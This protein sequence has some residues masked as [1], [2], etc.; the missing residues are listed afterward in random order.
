MF[1]NIIQWLA[2]TA[3]LIGLASPT[4]AQGPAR[5]PL[6]DPA[7]RAQ[8]QKLWDQYRD[9][10]GRPGGAEAL[11]QIMS[12]RAL[13][14]TKENS[15]AV[16]ALLRSNFSPDEKVFLIRIAG[17]QA[18]EL[19][20]KQARAD[21]QAFI[22]ALALGTE[23]PVIGEAAALM[24]SRMGFYP[25]SLTV[26]ARARAKNHISDNDYFGDLAHL[27]PAATSAQDQTKILRLLSDGKNSLARE[28]LANLLLDRQ[29]VTTLT[30][31]AITD[32]IAFLAQ[33]EPA[34]SASPTTISGVDVL[35]YGYWMN[36]LVGLNAKATGEPERIV[37]ARLLKIDGANPKTLI[38]VLNY[39]P[40]AVLVRSALDRRSLDKID[41]VVADFGEKSKNGWVQELVATAR[42]NL[43]EPKK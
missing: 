37:M 32:S 16:L 4:M 30:P 9:K 26:L 22:S 18:V 35:R 38:A 15:A 3:V 41:A 34:F 40:N 31:A 14:A 5:S 21:I 43:V 23:D 11:V 20:D 29:I 10:A 1:T 17:A 39:E 6:G 42:T 13:P 27:L 2:A 12:T 19:D 33:S 8:A 28:I 25:D 24:Y 7:A 36:A